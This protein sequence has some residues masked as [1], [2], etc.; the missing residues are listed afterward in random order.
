MHDE[1]ITI[2][3][4]RFYGSPWQPEFYDWAFNLPRGKA[5]KQKWDLIPENTDALITDGCPAEGILDQ[6]FDGSRVGCEELA[7]AINKIRPK[8]HICGHIHESY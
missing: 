7:K 2:E 6:T 3:N 1:S 8:L 5:H 4:I